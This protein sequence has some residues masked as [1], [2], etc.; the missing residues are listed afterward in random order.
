MDFKSQTRILLVDDEEYNRTAIK[1]ILKYHAKLDVERICDEA[2]NG[3]EAVMAMKN[4][5]KNNGLNKCQ[6]KLIL[7]DCNMPIMD[8]YEATK[9]IR[10]FLQDQ[11]IN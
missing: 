4:N 7:M 2:A 3:K 9:S 10:S 5:V 11:H 6:Y 8:G 1:I